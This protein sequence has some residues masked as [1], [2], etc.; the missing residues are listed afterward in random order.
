MRF[1][2]QVQQRGLSADDVML[3]V[4]FE[5]I[6][7]KDQAAILSVEFSLLAIM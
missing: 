7:L 2:N 6:I 1:A 3:P 5:A 4:Q